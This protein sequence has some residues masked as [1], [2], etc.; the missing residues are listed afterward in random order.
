MSNGSTPPRMLCAPLRLKKM[1]L[2]GI[3]PYLHG[4]ELNIKPLTILCG[5]NGSGKST[6]LAALHAFKTAT[7]ATLFPSENCSEADTDN[8][9]G[10]LAGSGRSQV[11][12]ILENGGLR[13]GRQTSRRSSDDRKSAIKSICQRADSEIVG[14]L[15][16][17]ELVW[18][19]PR[20]SL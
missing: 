19:K 8:P 17:D 5:E 14:F 2:R 11:N 13:V 15:R 9:V 20:E 1:T 4:A 18:S 7:E 6:W 16:V 3:G 12:Q 10:W